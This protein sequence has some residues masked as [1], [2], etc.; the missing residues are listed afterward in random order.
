[1][2]SAILDFCGED[3]VVN[4]HPSRRRAR[5]QPVSTGTPVGWEGEGE[6]GEGEVGADAPTSALP[7][8]SAYHVGASVG[9]GGRLG[10]LASGSDRSDPSSASSLDRPRFGVPP[11]G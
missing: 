4:D 5:P 11:L 1:M 3:E 9:G 2:R 7:I 6:G 8:V 10:T